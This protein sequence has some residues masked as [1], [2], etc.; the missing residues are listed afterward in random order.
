MYPGCGC[1]VC[2]KTLG[3][4]IPEGPDRER[5]GPAG[6]AGT[7]GAPFRAA[8]AGVGGKAGPLE[9]ATGTGAA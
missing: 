1:T 2:Q 9:T 4:G 7:E 8:L 6:R 3:P 5:R